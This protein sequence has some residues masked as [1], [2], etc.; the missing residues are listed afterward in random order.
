MFC[1]CLSVVATGYLHKVSVWL[2]TLFVVSVNRKCIQAEQKVILPPLH[3]AAL[4]RFLHPLCHA[5]PLLS[6]HPEQRHTQCYLTCRQLGGPRPHAAVGAAAGCRGATVQY[7]Y[8][9][10][11]LWINLWVVVPCVEVWSCS[12]KKGTC[13]IENALITNDCIW[14]WLLTSPHNTLYA[15]EFA[16]SAPSTFIDPEDKSLFPGLSEAAAEL[17]SWEWT[18][19]KTPKFSIQTA[20]K[21]VDGKFNSTARLHV[22]VRNGVMESCRLDVPS[23]WIPPR[24]SG[25]LS[26]LLVGERFCRQRAAA[27]LTA[28]LRCGS[29]ELHKRLHKLCEAVLSAM[30]WNNTFVFVFF[31]I[32][33]HKSTVTFKRLHFAFVFCFFEMSMGQSTLLTI[34]MSNTLLFT[35]YYL[36]FYYTG[37]CET[38]RKI[39]P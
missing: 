14:M 16:F 23:D 28:A 31:Y 1:L 38:K 3:P 30:A 6:R 5:P 4:G 2:Y 32:S 9:P 36:L 21:L 39:W 19:G 7:R 37:F 12:A 22:E 15:I 34:I 24:F 35:F 8:L 26:D 10:C 29:G 25:E 18:F 20:L 17:Q 13:Q 33:H 11:F 27:A